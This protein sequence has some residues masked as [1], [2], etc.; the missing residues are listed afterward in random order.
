MDGQDDV[1]RAGDRTSSGTFRFH[2]HSLNASGLCLSNGLSFFPVLVRD[3]FLRVDCSLPVAA[4][5]T[6]WDAACSLGR[7]SISDV[8]DGT[9]LDFPVSAMCLLTVDF[10]C[11]QE[12]ASR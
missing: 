11:V 12:M 2:G 6:P 7:A 4:E 8:L 1:W 3:H 9:C 10:P 5:V